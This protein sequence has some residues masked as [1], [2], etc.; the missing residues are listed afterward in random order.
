MKLIAAGDTHG[1][2]LW[3][4]ILEK[5]EPF[6]K[7]IFIGDYFDT[8]DAI[9]VDVQIA[10][11][12]EILEFKIANPD[13]VIL[14]LGN[15]DFHYL[16]GAGEDYSGFQWGRASDINEVLQPAVNA[17]LVQ[18][19]HIHDN[20]V[21]THAGI[22]KTWIANN[23]IDLNDL[24]NQL[25]HKLLAD[26]TTF[27]F[28]VGDN[29]DFSGDDVTQPPIWV[30]IP[31]LLKD[32]LDGY[33]F[34]VGHTM[35]KELTMMGDIIGIDTLGTSREYLKIENNVIKIGRIALD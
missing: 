13:R 24:E 26:V 10:N 5:E 23:E 35:I 12:K 34:V 8:K 15:H 33:I 19:C 29:M 22:T 6:D 1:R 21:F 20:F 17:G 7:F 14:L 2:R 32:K 3:K 11:F 30:R 25:N 28:S 9:T 4:K 18:M 16:K 31:S 27:K